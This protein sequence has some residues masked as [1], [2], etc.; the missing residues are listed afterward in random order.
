MK[1]FKT[2]MKYYAGA[3]LVSMAATSQAAVIAIDSTDV[4]AQ[5]AGAA[6]A[7][8]AVGI[9]VLSIGALVKSYSL[10]KSMLGR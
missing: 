1:R 10:V 5:I 2:N 9:A 4:V 8:A 7:I 3:A 6:T